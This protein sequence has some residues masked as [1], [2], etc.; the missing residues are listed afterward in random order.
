MSDRRS[1]VGVFLACFLGSVGANAY[2]IAPA[3]IVPLLVAAFDVDK[4]GAGVAISAAV[5]GSVLVQIPFGF[6]MDRYDNRPLMTAGTAVFVP[7]AI[8]GSFATAYP[9]F[10]A[11]RAVAGLAGG[12]VFVLGTNVVAQVFAGKRQG[13]VTTVFIASAPLG[14]AISQF[15]GPLLADAFGWRTAFVAYPLVSAVGYLVFRLSRPPAIRTGD[16]ITPREFGHALRNRAVL[17]VSFSGFCSYLLYIFMNS[18]M[19]T[20]ATERLPL[21]LG[22]AGAIT[23]LLPAVGMVARPV[24]GWLS[25]YVGY[26]RRLIVV[27]SLAFALPA[28]FVVSRSISIALF[29]LVML[30]VGFSLQFGMGVYYVYTRELAADGRGGTSLAV[31]TSIA[32]SGTLVSPTLGGWLIGAFSWQTTFLLYALIGVVGIGLLFLTR[33]SSPGPTG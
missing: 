16:R 6:L 22:E 25:D 18:W 21:S 2:M 11:S 7:V 9:V 24:G 1:R 32:F 26:R 29:S 10:L 33:D 20:Y 15:G 5:L 17:L 8:A 12:A 28:F 30:S 4:A 19:P 3:S 13:V 27:C 31:F 23:A 14:F